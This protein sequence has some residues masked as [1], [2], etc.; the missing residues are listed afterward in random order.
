[1]LFH[2]FARTERPV[3]GEEVNLGAE[4]KKTED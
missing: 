1:M 4:I 3:A 2:I